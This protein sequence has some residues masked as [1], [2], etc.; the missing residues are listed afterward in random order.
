MLSAQRTKTFWLLCRTESRARA[1][2]R[3]HRSRSQSA[4]RVPECRANV[5]FGFQAR[6]GTAHYSWSHCARTERERAVSLCMRCAL[7]SFVFNYLIYYAFS[8][9]SFNAAH[10]STGCS[11]CCCCSLSYTLPPAARCFPVYGKLRA[12]QPLAQV[13]FVLP[14][15]RHKA[16]KNETNVVHAL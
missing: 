8:W 10:S 11:R 14:N 1:A 12:S 7:F 13:E 5:S 3:A 15:K 4:E 16:N 2:S 6:L 9:L